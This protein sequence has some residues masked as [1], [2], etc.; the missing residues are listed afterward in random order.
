MKLCSFQKHVLLMKVF[1]YFE[2]IFSM[3]G[4]VYSLAFVTKETASEVFLILFQLGKLK[5]LSKAWI[6]FKELFLRLV[7]SSVTIELLFDVNLAI[8]KG[9][10]VSLLETITINIIL[11]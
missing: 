2:I 9:T 1:L 7:T 4:F 10:E 11:S 8:E 3:I 5:S 6:T